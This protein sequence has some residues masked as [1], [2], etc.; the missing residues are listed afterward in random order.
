MVSH[1]ERDIVEAVLTIQY[2]SSTDL[3]PFVR[4]GKHGGS[5]ETR[6]RTARY[7]ELGTNVS[8]S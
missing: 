8:S 1:Y 4:L 2:S 6:F 7:D 3:D 5:S